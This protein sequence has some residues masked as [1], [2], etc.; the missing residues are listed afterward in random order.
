MSSIEPWHGDVLVVDAKQ[1][2][3]ELLVGELDRYAVRLRFFSTGESALRWAGT[4]CSTLWL[5]NIQLPDMSGISLL[6]HLRRRL[7][8]VSVVIVGD[9]CTVEDELAARAAGANAY[10]CKPASAAWLLACQPRRGS[11]AVRASPAI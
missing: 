3:Y 7:P 5:V 11:P 1:E 9:V 4:C 6:T 2:G 10:F 8:R